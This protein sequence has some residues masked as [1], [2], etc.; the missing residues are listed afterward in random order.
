[1]KTSIKS[2]HKFVLY[3]LDRRVFAIIVTILLLGSTIVLAQVPQGTISLD[4]PEFDNYFTNS[5]KIPVVSGKILNLASGD[6]S[7]IKISYSIVTPFYNY[8]DKKTCKVSND[9]TFTL[10]IDYPFPYQQI[11]FRMGDTVYTCLYANSDLIIELDASKIDKKRGI[12][13]NGKGLRFLGSDGELNTLMNNRILFKRKE[14]LAIRNEISSLRTGRSLH[15]E[16]YLKKYNEIYDKLISIDKEFI[17]SNPSKYDWLIENERLSDYYSNIS[18]RYVA[19]KI[20]DEL[21]GKMKSHTSYSI[22]NSGQSFYRNLL[23]Y[24]SISVGKF[25][26]S[27]WETFS[28]YSKID[29]NGKKLIDS[30]SYYSKNSD[31]K[32]YNR[33]MSRAFA[34]FSDT[35]A[36]IN[37]LKTVDFLNQNFIPSKADNLK[38]KLGSMDKGEQI[39]IDEIV[40]KNL[41]TTWCIKG[42][43][44]QYKDITSN[45]LRV[46]TILQESK[47]LISNVNIGKSISELD[48]GAKLYTY[49]TGNASEL[50]SNLKSAFK[51]KALLLDF[52]ATWCGPCLVEMPHSIKLQNEAKTLPLEFIYLCTSNNSSI[53]KW[54]LKIAELKIPGTHIFVSE[55]IENELMRFFSASGFPSYR[56][57]NSDG[58]IK[59]EFKRPSLSDFKILNKLISQK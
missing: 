4:D 23:S 11:W 12:Q 37:A 20:P 14:Q 58:V 36:T 43:N 49:D 29:E 19:D 18:P 21:W 13:F 54:K 32:S 47:P 39:L 50:L 57:I 59:T 35:L 48:F 16:E 51:D 25:S 34:L 15:I 5:S 1:M 17:A 7:Q 56:L 52:W 41:S 24:I 3:C 30:L 27:D 55:S 46:K 31:L 10:Q 2:L 26:F 9:G 44:A 53:D 45:A 22:S 38:I 28:H 33:L 8:Q 6:F 42:K 40:L